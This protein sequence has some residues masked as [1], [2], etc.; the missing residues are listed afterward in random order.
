MAYAEHPIFRIRIRN[1]AMIDKNEMRIGNY[2]FCDGKILWLSEIQHLKEVKEWVY[3]GWHEETKQ[4][5][6]INYFEAEPIPLTPE[7]LIKCGFYIVENAYQSKQLAKRKLFSLD[8]ED[9]DICFTKDNEL[10]FL[11]SNKLSIMINDT[12]KYKYL[13]QLQNLYFALT[14]Q[15]L[16]IDL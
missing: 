5:Y 9:I 10:L 14:G 15:E 2:F 6:S 12:S 16:E 13:H 7:I 3:E 1:D 8:D 4:R 11:R